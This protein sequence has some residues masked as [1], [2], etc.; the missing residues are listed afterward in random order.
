MPHKPKSSPTKKSAPTQGRAKHPYSPEGRAS[1]TI[2]EFCDRNA[3]SRG[4]YLLLRKAGLG[5]VEMRPSGLAH[6]AIRISVAAE[7]RW[8]AEAEKRVV[9]EADQLA[10]RAKRAGK[11]GG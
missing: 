10:D 8:I 5:P 9:A 1:F 7:A 4:A 3:I 2:Q 6:G 11:R